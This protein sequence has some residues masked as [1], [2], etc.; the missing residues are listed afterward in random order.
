MHCVSI[1]SATIQSCDEQSFFCHVRDKML[2]ENNP[3][4]NARPV[5]DEML[6]KSGS[7]INITNIASLRDAENLLHRFL[8][9]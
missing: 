2:V 3:I 8:P 5:R 7:V 4:K 1:F 6:V 9:T